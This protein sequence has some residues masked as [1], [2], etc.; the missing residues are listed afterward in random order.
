MCYKSY[1]FI[2]KFVSSI[3]N[4]FQVRNGVLSI[5]GKHFEFIAVLLM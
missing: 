1:F 3:L 5:Q 4:I 2:L